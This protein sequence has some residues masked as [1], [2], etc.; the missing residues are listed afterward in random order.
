MANELISPTPPDIE[1]IFKRLR[2]NPSNK[3]CFDCGARNPTWSS[4]TYGVF[5]CI[6]CSSVHRNLGVHLSFVRSTNLDTNWSWIQLRAMQIGGNANA[7]A[8]FKQHG[9]ES[10]DAQVKYHSKAAAMYKSRIIDLATKAQQQAGSN[11]FFDALKEQQS[12]QSKVPSESE[13]FGSHENEEHTKEMKEASLS[14]IPHAPIQK[15]KKITLGQK[16]G[17]S[18]GAQKIKMN[19]TDVE[20]KANDFDTERSKL[21]ED[22]KQCKPTSETNQLAQSLSSKFLMQEVERKQNEAAKVAKDP[23]KAD[24]LDR[25]GFGL[26]GTQSSNRSIGVHS[27]TSGI[28]TIQQEESTM[29]KSVDKRVGREKETTDF[30]WEIV[31]EQKPIKKGGFDELSAIKSDRSNEK[32]EFFDAWDTTAARRTA[33]K[34]PTK[35]PIVN[36]PISAS[37]NGADSLKKFGKAKAISS[38]QYFGRTA[39]MDMDTRANLSKFEGSQGIGSADLFGDKDQQQRSSTW[40]EHV[41][42]MSDIKDSVMQG[43]SKMTEKLSG[44]SSSVSSYLSDRY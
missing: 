19:F 35:V 20:Q 4:V 23:T 21:R 38:D 2:A 24:Q 11:T 39:E 16:K 10:N 13:F 3:V 32:E 27:I 7:V 33:E 6:D 15:T 1:N 36:T 8:F 37:S 28:R 14:E 29:A 17:G 25:L 43:V 34:K 22:S 5:I 44:L 12:P 18:L 41:P 26:M 31:D 42:E 9:C 40:Q 30:D